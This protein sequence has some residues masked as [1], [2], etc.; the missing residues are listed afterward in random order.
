MKNGF[1]LDTQ[2][3][4]MDDPRIEWLRDRSYLALDIKD[5]AIFDD[6]LER[7]EGEA[8]RLIAKFLNETPEELAEALVFYK[9][10]NEEE[11]EVEVECGVY[12][13]D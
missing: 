10:L 3:Y 4:I 11:E 2:K 1:V 9:T 6:L 13:H 5:D 7:D 8:E 12:I